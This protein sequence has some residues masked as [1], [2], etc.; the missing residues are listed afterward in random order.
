MALMY[1]YILI[2]TIAAIGSIIN[3][4]FIMRENKKLRKQS[5]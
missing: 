1:F 3:V 2:G 5:N 4:Y